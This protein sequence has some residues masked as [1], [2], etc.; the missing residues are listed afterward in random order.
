MPLLVVSNWRA[1]QLQHVARPGGAE[2]VRG[3][4][5]GTLERNYPVGELGQG[6]VVGLGDYL[7]I[8]RAGWV[9]IAAS[10]VI[11]IAVSAVVSTI[12][13]T[14]PLYAS[15]ARVFVSTPISVG[16]PV[17]TQQGY[18]FITQRVRSYAGIIESESMASR[19][20]EVN[21]LEDDPADLAARVSAQVVTDTELVE[22]TV[23]DPSPGDA[24][25]LATAYANE[26]V[27]LVSE[28]EQPPSG[29]DPLMSA[30]VVD[31]AKSPASP[32]S[33]QPVRTITLA[34]VLGLLV[35]IGIVVLRDV[36]DMTV[37]GSDELTEISGA[38][39]L[40]VIAFDS[41]AKEHP[42]LVQIDP[43][44]ASRGLPKT[45]DQ[46]AVCRRGRRSEG[47]CRH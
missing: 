2:P 29:G 28:I 8:A 12:T 22:I 9:W 31:P 21:G 33:P 35:G 41:D 5:R 1:V 44:P 32:G 43:E 42:L 6:A 10:I 20:I 26:F 7:K 18:P 15:S 36:L 23:S 19:V 27:V 14:N 45:A 46:S 37:S 3:R 30:S 13:M 17:D 38:P 11:A 24:R 34:A 25:A 16:G 4:A 47:H 40:G 39:T